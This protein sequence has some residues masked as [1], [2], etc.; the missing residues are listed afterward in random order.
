MP[1]PYTIPGGVNSRGG[2]RRVHITPGT[3]ADLDYKA[4]QIADEERRR[5]GASVGTATDAYE[6]SRTALESLI[7]PNALFSKA[8][9]TIGARSK[10]SLEN[11]RS[12]LGARGI[13]PSS[14]AAGGMLSRLR[15]EA[16]THGRPVFWTH[17]QE[18]IFGTDV[19][20]TNWRNALRSKAAS[21]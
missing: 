19:R 7:D 16:R 8:A 20:D 1:G 13:S 15:F 6:R 12:S 11:L 14:G 2:E 4:S 9:D 10:A 18:R 3:G 17:V 21:V 5:Y